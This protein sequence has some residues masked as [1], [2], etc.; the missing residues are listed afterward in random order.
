MDFDI[1]KSSK[2]LADNQEQFIVVRDNIVYL[3]VVGTELEYIT[4]TATAAEDDRKVIP[5]KDQDALI[6]AVLQVANHHN[7][8]NNIKQDQEGR[9]YVEFG[10][11]EYLSDVY[12]LA[13]GFFEILDKNPKI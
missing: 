10:K 8:K 5:F 9:Y 6:N 1:R 11:C 7:W 4:M 13:Q 12:R 3:R 2:L